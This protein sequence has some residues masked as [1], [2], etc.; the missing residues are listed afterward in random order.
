MKH[1]KDSLTV[2]SRAKKFLIAAISAII[3]VALVLTCALCF[4]QQAK[5]VGVN[6]EVNGG[7]QPSRTLSV[8]L[9]GDQTAFGA[10]LNGDIIDFTYSGGVRSITLPKGTYT[11][12]V[13]GAQGGG[14][15]QDGTFSAGVGLGGYMKGNITFSATT[16]VYICIGGKGTDGLLGKYGNP[17]SSAPGGYNGGGNSG[18]EMN[19]DAN[20]EG[21]GGGG[22][23]HMAT[24]NRGTLNNYASYTT[25]LLI[26]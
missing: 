8:N 19:T 18:C 1:K 15:Y 10:L 25:E 13:W 4:T 17:A 12:E 16:T 3:A 21:G 7:A 9:S 22:A 24:T 11:L 23:T 26:V 2:P 20:D 5:R 14:G 6:N